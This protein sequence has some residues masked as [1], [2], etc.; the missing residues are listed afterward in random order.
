[1]EEDV[2]NPIAGCSESGC[3]RP[4]SNASRKRGVKNDEKG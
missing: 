4:T 1:M 2:A 3:F